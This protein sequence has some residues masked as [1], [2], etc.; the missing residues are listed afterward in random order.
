ML[1]RVERK[2]D[3]KVRS[4]RGRNIVKNPQEDGPL[5]Q[6][7]VGDRSFEVVESIE[8]GGQKKVL[9]VREGKTLYILKT[10]L[11][12]VDAKEE[13][14][15]VDELNAAGIGDIEEVEVAENNR[16]VVKY[17]AGNLS[18]IFG[19]QCKRL[20]GEDKR[21]YVEETLLVMM[22]FLA[23]KLSQIDRWYRKNKGHPF[24]H[25]DIKPQNIL[26]DPHSEKNRGKLV[27]IDFGALPRPFTNGKYF[28]T[29][30]TPDFAPPPLNCDSPPQ[31][32]FDK[33]F[34]KKFDVY[35]IVKSAKWLAENS[36]VEVGDDFSALFERFLEEDHN[37][38]PS[39]E[40]LEKDIRQM[41]AAR[42][43]KLRNSISIPSDIYRSV[44]KETG[45]KY[46]VWLASLAALAS[47]LLL[48]RGKMEE[49]PPSP[50]FKEHPEVVCSQGKLYLKPSSEIGLYLLQKQESGDCYR[51]L[52]DRGKRIRDTLSPPDLYPLDKGAYILEDA[53]KVEDGKKGILLV[54]EDGCNAALYRPGESAFMRTECR[55]AAC[56]ASEAVSLCSESGARKRKKRRGRRIKK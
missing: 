5:G 44:K 37:N 12:G 23:N 30:Y 21:R 6:I 42:S 34:M 47:V 54:V 41:A 1:R 28:I 36:G 31:V 18:Y 7:R 27:L 38:R 46:F 4:G 2:E 40:E 9:L 16:I 10:L 25:C 39:L 55:G 13:K 53:K 45:F 43:I 32:I 29:G 24:F 14:A 22:W 48:F 26:V 8:E 50:I 15:L 3:V 33:E 51:Y 19:E 35:S 20:K 49:Q 56:N 52:R 11:R 17:M